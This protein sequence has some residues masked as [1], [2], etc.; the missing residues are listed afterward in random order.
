[1]IDRP[2]RMR[3]EVSNFRC[4]SPDYDQIIVASAICFLLLLA[5]SSAALSI[6]ESRYLMFCSLRL[7]DHIHHGFWDLIP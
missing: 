1:M 2:L 3:F 6:R 7:Q 4:R 5:L